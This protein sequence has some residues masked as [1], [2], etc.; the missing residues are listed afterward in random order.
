MK[1]KT[2]ILEITSYDMCNKGYLWLVY[3]KKKFNLRTKKS[4]MQILN[5]N[6][7]FTSLNG[8]YHIFVLCALQLTHMQDINVYLHI[9]I[10][11]YNPID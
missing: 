6:L 3:L 4:L 8:C 9:D 1:K 7:D 10:Q 11:E 5:L 2:A